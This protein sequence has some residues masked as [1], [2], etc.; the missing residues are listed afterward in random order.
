MIA[1][2]EE[3]RKAHPLEEV[4]DSMTPANATVIGYCRVSTE[5]QGSGGI[6]LD[7]QEH[8]LAEYAK[9]RGWTVIPMREIASGTT[10]AKR[11]V[12]QQALA[13]LDSGEA[14]AI[15]VTKL[16]RL[17]RSVIDAFQT[18]NRAEKR[19]WDLVILDMG[20][21]TT[22]AIG[23]AMFGMAAVFAQLYRDQI[24]E[25][26][27]AALAQKRRQ[28]ITLGRPRKM[29]KD[30]IHRMRE[31]RRQ[32]KSYETIALTLNAEGI[33]GS[34]GGKWWKQSVAKAFARYGMGE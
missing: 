22:T 19:G 2:D 1:A 26:T 5:E 33:P 23:K 17:S 31:L 10:M 14:Q 21:D 16:D 12:M 3:P 15:M 4:A 8:A 6:S 9:A 7:A 32:G 30:T 28:G 20:L 24:S 29:P 13:M 11:P 27:K 34:Q 25:N 18:M